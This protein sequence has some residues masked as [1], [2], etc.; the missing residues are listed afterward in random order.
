MSVVRMRCGSRPDVMFVN[1]VSLLEGVRIGE[2]RHMYSWRN[3]DEVNPDENVCHVSSRDVCHMS[4][5]DV[6]HVL[7]GGGVPTEH[8]K[9]RM[10]RK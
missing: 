3:P 7:L 1:V 2:A 4:S 10:Y 6:C 8:T 5:R 9:Y